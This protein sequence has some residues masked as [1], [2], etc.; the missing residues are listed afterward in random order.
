MWSVWKVGLNRARTS[1]LG[2]VELVACQLPLLRMMKWQSVPVL[3]ALYRGVADWTRP[4]W[5]LMADQVEQASHTW[6]HWERSTPA[7]QE[8]M[9]QS[10]VQSD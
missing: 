7:R 5:Q 10:L 2:E 3:V 8:Q 1:L 4:S 6:I 9:S